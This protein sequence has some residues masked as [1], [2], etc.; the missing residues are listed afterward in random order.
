MITIL[1]GCRWKGGGYGRV[2][3]KQEGGGGENRGG[4]GGAPGSDIFKESR[5]LNVGVGKGKGKGRTLM[6]EKGKALIRRGGS[7]FYG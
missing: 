6:R 5:E 4:R 1:K 2:S 3:A 7:S